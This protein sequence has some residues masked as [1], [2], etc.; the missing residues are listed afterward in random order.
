MKENSI[1]MSEYPEKHA[2]I[3]TSLLNGALT[4]LQ[5]KVGFHA[6]ID[7]VFLAASV[8][9]KKGWKLLDMGCGVGS[10]GLCVALKNK[11]IHLTGLDIQ[12]ELIDIAHQNAALNGIAEQCHFFQGNIKTEKTIENN[13]FN[14]VMMNPPY[15]E[16]GTHTPSPE[17]IKAYSHGEGSSGTCLDDWIKYAHTKLKNGGYLTIIHRADRLDDVI[18]ALE[19]KRWFGS[20]VIFPLYSRAGDDAKRVIIQAR[21]ERYAPLI[22]KAG[23]VIHEKDGKYTEAAQKVLRDFETIVL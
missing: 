9:V 6:S 16:Q 7:T 11:T 23:M 21:K 5:P 13:H 10:A 12:E 18:V 14:A 3:E 1:G 20:L 22:L 15:L 17:K 8:T 4:L 2:V 19:K